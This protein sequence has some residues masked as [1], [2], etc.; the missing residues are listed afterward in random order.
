MDKAE[1]DTDLARLR[2]AERAHARNQDALRHA[3][4]RH[5]QD[6]AH[7][8]RLTEDIGD[9]IARRQDTRGEKF[10]MTVDGQR[11]VKRAEA[12]Q[13]LKDLLQNEAVA[14]GAVQQR[15][16]RP[17]H[18]GGFPVTAHIAASLG[19]ASLTIALDG[20]PGTEIHLP[21]RDLRDADPAGMVT[22]LENRLHRLEERK[23]STLAD[24]ERARRD[25]THACES[26]GQ[27]FSQADQLA[28][29]HY[30]ARQIDEQ[31]QKMAEPQ[32]P[33]KQNDPEGPSAP[34]SSVNKP[35]PEPGRPKMPQPASLPPAAT[36]HA[37]RRAGQAVSSPG[38]HRGI[39]ALRQLDRTR[40][41][42]RGPDLEAGQ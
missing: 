7:L 33:A 12:G 17:G 32:Q 40:Y 14:A 27:P 42:C 10:T 36:R 4:T 28:R 20:A 25:V 21:V 16:V 37:P 19:Q 22:R 24:T 13:H 8:T 15:T 11:H 41:P 31:L 6:I 38:S 39:E 35:E 30:R 26:I 5:E 2:R 18:L 23:A 29:A 1:A 34:S 9:A 3:V